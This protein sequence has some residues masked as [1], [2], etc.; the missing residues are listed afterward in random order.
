MSENYKIVVVGSKSFDDKSF[1]F[2]VLDQLKNIWEMTENKI[3]KLYSGNFTGVAKYAR[4]WSELNEINY[5]EHNLFSDK[6][7]NPLFE[8]INVPE[9]VVKNDEYYKD[10][11]EFLMSEKINLL[12]LLP[13]NDGEL[14]VSSQNIKRMAESAGISILNAQELYKQIRTFRDSKKEEVVGVKKL[15]SLDKI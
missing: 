1:V 3:E 15:S 7:D 4:E 8:Y 2:G 11:K 6:K 14:G 9:F 10:G 5:K 13:N 12:I